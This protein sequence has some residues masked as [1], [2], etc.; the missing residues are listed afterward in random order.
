[1][2]VLFSPLLISLGQTAAIIVFLLAH[3]SEPFRNRSRISLLCG[4][5]ILHTVCQTL[6]HRTVSERGLGSFPAVTFL[7]TTWIIYCV[8]LFLWTHANWSS[9]CFLAFILLL[10]DNCVWPLMSSLSRMAW[11]INYLYDGPLLLRL[12][13]ILL[14]TVL[15]ILLVL[16]IRK[17]LPEPDRLQLNRYD[18]ILAL[19]IVIPFLYIRTLSGQSLYQD[20]KTVQI[21]MTV[22]CLTAVITLAAEVGH[23]SSEHEKMRE[24]QMQSI[25]HGQQALFE[26]K[27][28]NVD[29]INRKYHDMKNTLLYLR[30]HTEE[31]STDS[32]LDE[33]LNTIEPYSKIVT[34][35]NEVLDI[36]LNEKLSHCSQNRITCIPCLNGNAFDFI[37]PLDLC[38]L[39]GNAMDNAIE[40]CVKIPE[41]G[42]RFIRIY[43]ATKGETV[44][45]ELRNTFLTKPEFHNGLPVTSKSDKDNHGYGLQNMIA[46]A[47][48]YDG[49]LNCSVEGDEFV[50]TVLLSPTQGK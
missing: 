26:Q 50:L 12:P 43:S 9:C 7:L 1:M 41:E 5:Y 42:L 17:L 32:A 34:T 47:E 3:D 6:L 2:E 39:L 23:S 22:C 18:A 8:F 10:V 28:R 16:L 33:L 13:F 48:K 21:V 14:F 44:I 4:F 38:T 46:I 19:A 35:G 37:K 29:Q 25:L 27:L 11:G 20:N 24:A 49:S 45:L 30:A 15:E 36:I 31:K 40:S